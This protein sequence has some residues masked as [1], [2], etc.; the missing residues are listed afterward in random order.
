M[1]LSNSAFYVFNTAGSIYT[2]AEPN[3]LHC[4]YLSVFFFLTEKVKFWFI[5]ATLLKVKL[6][7]F[8]LEIYQMFKLLVSYFVQMLLKYTHKNY[9]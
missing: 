2:R 1:L 6:E 9:K 7:M 8:L 3:H 5:Y 4:F